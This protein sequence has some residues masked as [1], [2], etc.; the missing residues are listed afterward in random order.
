MSEAITEAPTVEPAVASEPETFTREYVEALR[1]ENAK[2]R[3][4][5]SEST[6]AARAAEKAR[7]AAMTESERAVAEAEA[8]G[9]TAAVT[10]YGQRLARAEFVA[11]AAR[12]NSS[13][14][15]AAVL[16]DINLAKYVTDDGE[17]D[18]DGIAAAVARLIPVPSANPRPV[19]DADLGSRGAPMALNGDGIEQALKRKLGIT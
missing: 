13:Y 3:T 19:G 2:Y 15:A 18:V 12:L 9:R 6:E 7:M 10:Q 4:K 8:R 11:A 16:D 5:A 1:K 17:P 14:D